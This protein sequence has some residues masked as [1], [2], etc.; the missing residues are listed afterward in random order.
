MKQTLDLNLEVKR[1]ESRQ[2]EGHGSTFGNVDLGG[3]VGMPGA[4]QRILAQHR[5]KGALPPMFWM[6]D[7]SQIAGRW[8]DM[9]EDER[10]LKV[11]G[12][13]AKT[14][15]GDE[16]HT[17]LNMKAFRGLSIGYGTVEAEFDK[18][19]NRRLKEIDLWEVS[20]VSLAMNPLAEVEAVKARLSASGEYV[21]TPRQF[22]DWLHRDPR[23]SKSVA[24]GM[25]SRVFGVSAG[26]RLD[27]PRRESGSVNGEAAELTEL[28]NIVKDS[29]KRT[30]T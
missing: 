20:L 1:R 7:P 21:P 25:A 11:K 18:D 4:F 29:M 3:D 19:G 26:W 24:C 12:E 27:S 8:L 2:F 23:C 15:L 22:E 13:L 16:L 9:A 6:H 17:L 28:M 30:S 5:N 14:P 10:G